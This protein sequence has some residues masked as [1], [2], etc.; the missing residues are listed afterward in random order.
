MSATE[1]YCPECVRWNL[2]LVEHRKIDVT[3]FMARSG[4]EFNK[5][6]N[7]FRLF[8]HDAE[9]PFYL[10]SLPMDSWSNS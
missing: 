2:S 7:V 3:S 4:M 5:Y 10:A 8:V 6:S 9:V 1:G